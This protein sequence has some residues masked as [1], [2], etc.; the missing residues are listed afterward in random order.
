MSYTLNVQWK[1]NSLNSNKLSVPQNTH[2]LKSVEY[3]MNILCF[4]DIHHAEEI[5]GVSAARE[6][7]YA[8]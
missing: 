6:E 8:V 1:G 5:P 3:S 2:L 7:L 4:L